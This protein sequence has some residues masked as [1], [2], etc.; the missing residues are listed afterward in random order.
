M[1]AERE[2]NRVFVVNREEGTWGCVSHRPVSEDEKQTTPKTP[3][4]T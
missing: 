1:G 4:A 3:Q 2:D